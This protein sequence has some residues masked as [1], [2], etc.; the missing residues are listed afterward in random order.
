MSRYLRGGVNRVVSE[1]RLLLTLDEDSQKKAEVGMVFVVY[2]DGPHVK[3][4]NGKS[5]GT[6]E[7]Q[8]AKVVL[9][10]V[11]PEFCYADSVHEMVPRMF[12]AGLGYDPIKYEWVQ[13]RIAAPP[14]PAP[15]VRKP[16]G[17]KGSDGDTAFEEAHRARNLLIVEGDRVRS[18]VP[19]D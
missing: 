14:E 17:E 1:T 12:T 3:A 10:H 16:V 18:L 13:R 7:I 4:W 11:Q 15:E 6:L 2:E 8:K 9:V 5:L 19:V